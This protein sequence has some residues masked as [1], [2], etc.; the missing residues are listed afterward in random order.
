MA[1]SQVTRHAGDDKNIHPFTII[2]GKL[3]K[4]S[5]GKFQ[6]SQSISI[7]SISHFTPIFGF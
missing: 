4:K 1:Q 2:I 3:G 5:H 6:I 7:S